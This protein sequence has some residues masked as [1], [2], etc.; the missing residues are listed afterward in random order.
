VLKL[1][2]QRNTQNHLLFQEERRRNNKNKNQSK[3]SGFCFYKTKVL[4]S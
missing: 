3:S 2:N 4:V 1:E